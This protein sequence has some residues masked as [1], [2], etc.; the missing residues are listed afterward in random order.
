MYICKQIYVY[1]YNTYECTYI[2]IYICIYICTCIYFI[3]TCI[4]LYISPYIHVTITFLI[5]MCACPLGG[6]SSQK[7]LFF[8][9]EFHQRARFDRNQL[10]LAEDL[11]QIA[12]FT[13]HKPSLHSCQQHRGKH[14]HEHGQHFA[15][16]STLHPI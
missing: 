10:G 1:V 11:S 3:Y 5:S 14:T 12:L 7:L 15:P 8:L 9:L 2:Y 16:A 13:V 6:S 4:Y